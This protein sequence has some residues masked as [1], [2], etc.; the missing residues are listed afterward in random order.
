[1]PNLPGT[2][3]VPAGGEVKSVV[4]PLDGN[5]TLS[6][7]QRASL[8][9]AT[10]V[11]ILG[12]AVIVSLLV[13]WWSTT[14]Q[15]PIIPAGT[16]ENTS[17]LILENYKTLRDAALDDTLKILDAFVVKILLPIFTSFVG[18]FFGSQA[19]GAKGS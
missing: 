17:K 4:I 8:S 6:P 15:P 16:A 14:P 10:A 11:G 9:G 19:H 7:L 2:A 5:V 13:R 12:A 3:A 18:Y 1:M